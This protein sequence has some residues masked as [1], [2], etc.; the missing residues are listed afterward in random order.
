M[1]D[2]VTIAV[3]DFLSSWI[4][5]FLIML[6]VLVFVHE[7][8]HYLVA[9]R[10][11][12]RVEV[13]SIGFGPELFGWTDKVGTRWKF[14]AVPLGGYVKMFGDQGAASTPSGE[15]REMTPEERKVSFHFK[16]VGQRAAIV[17]AGPAV[18]YVFAVLILAVL[19]GTVGQTYTPPI[20]GN[21]EEG[22]AAA[23]AGIRSGDRIVSV[24]GSDVDRFEDIQERMLLHPGA[25]MP[26][27]VERNGER[28]TVTVTVGRDEIEDERGNIQVIGSFGATQMI[29]PYVGRVLADSAAEEA[30]L[31]AGDRFVSINGN[32][33]VSFEDVRQQV[34]P[35]PGERLEVVIERD[36]R[37]MTYEITPRL[38]EQEMADGEV[39]RV[40]LLGVGAQPSPRRTY[41]AFGS[42]WEA[43]VQTVEL[44]K[45]I[46]VSVGQIIGGDR[47]V[48][49]LGGPLRIAEISGQ[50]AERGVGNFLWVMALL[51][52]NLCLIN[53]LPIPMLDG[54]HLLFYGIEAVRGRPLSAKAQEIGFRIGLALVL[55]LMFLVLW[56]DLVHFNLFG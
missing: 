52:L 45:M 6:T 38:H 20:V 30:G 5:P 11:G 32:P 25:Q 29:P 47:S 50:S 16:R 39:R 4:L 12:V 53:L 10:N 48:R 49:E 43:T 18:N 31:Q 21:L 23:S 3:I 14:S 17:F 8:G 35:N 24:D 55:T 36:G 15:L 34:A 33:I 28:L 1:L 7:M 41:G 37:R 13:F 40:G 9:R 46:G 19:F 51:S 44:T 2:G 54:G 42:V 26:V 56:N 27:T 22:G